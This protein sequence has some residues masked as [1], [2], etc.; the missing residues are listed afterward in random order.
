ML[1]SCIVYNHWGH[2]TISCS[3]RAC[4]MILLS[5]PLVYEDNC[6]FL[7]KNCIR[8]HLQNSQKTN[9]QCIIL[10]YN[11]H[12]PWTW[13]Y[14]KCQNQ[15]SYTSGLDI[16][17]YYSPLYLSWIGE[18]RKRIQSVSLSVSLSLCPWWLD[19]FSSYLVSWS[20]TMGCWCM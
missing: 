11:G 6:Y 4:V 16:R 14:S 1:S 9:G 12:A 3:P 18:Y 10:H 2:T 8:I 17:H 7:L 20:D 15:F 19:G 5:T 13:F